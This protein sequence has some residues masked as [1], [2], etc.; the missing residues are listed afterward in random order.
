MIPGHITRD[1]M[2]RVATINATVLGYSG[3]VHYAFFKSLLEEHPQLKV[4][5]VLGV[6]HGRD[7]CYICDILRRYHPNREMIVTGVDKFSDTPCDDWPEEKNGMGWKEAG[8]GEPP[9]YEKALANISRFKGSVKLFLISVSDSTFLCSVGQPINDFV[10]IDTSHDYACV[11]RQLKQVKRVCVGG[12]T[13]LAGDD[14]SDVSNAGGSWG[15]KS[16]VADGLTAHEVF[17][18]W[19]W[20]SRALNLKP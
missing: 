4:M 11:S 5:L 14:Y 19:I 16:A 18:E 2:D 9:S 7:I 10:Y 20:I 8:F 13:I 1:D 6:Y 15:V 12:E 17:G 3:P